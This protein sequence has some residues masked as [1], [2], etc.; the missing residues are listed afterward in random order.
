MLI[1]N[2]ALSGGEHDPLAPSLDP[3]MGRHPQSQPSFR[4]CW[5]R[6]TSPGS[7]LVDLWPSLYGGLTCTTHATSIESY[8]QITNF[9]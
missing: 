1:D 6:V 8:K 5:S 4:Q 7:T 2:F 9:K 3:P